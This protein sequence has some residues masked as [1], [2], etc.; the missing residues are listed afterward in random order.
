MS[1]VCI[2]LEQSRAELI[3]GAFFH[4][5]DNTSPPAWQAVPSRGYTSPAEPLSTRSSSSARA[6]LYLKP[7]AR[8]L[9]GPVWSEHHFNPPPRGLAPSTC[10]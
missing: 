1:S 2:T 9:K 5:F 10:S 6:N 3:P 8:R 4:S 7:N